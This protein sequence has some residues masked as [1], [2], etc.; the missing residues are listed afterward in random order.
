MPLFKPKI[1][2]YIGPT[3]HVHEYRL[4]RYHIIIFDGTGLFGNYPIFFVQG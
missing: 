3:L 2:I 1:Y 4:Y